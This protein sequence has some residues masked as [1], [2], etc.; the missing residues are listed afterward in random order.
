ME[1]SL[2]SREWPLIAFTLLGQC[3]AGML[4]SW[5][6]YEL[7]GELPP[8]SPNGEAAWIIPAAITVMLGAAGLTA[9]LHLRKPQRAVLAASN[10]QRS[11]LSREMAFSLFFGGSTLL[12]T[13]LQFIQLPLVL[14]RLGL[15][16]AAIVF[17][18]LLLWS[19]I[20]L[21]SLRT[22]PAWNSPATALSFILSAV[23]LGPTALFSLLNLAGSSLEK[24]IPPSPDAAASTSALLLVA[25]PLQMLI[26]YL[27]KRGLAKG[28]RA[29]RTSAARIRGSKT[30]VWIRFY[31]VISAVML[32]GIKLAAG[33][34][35]GP[36]VLC[37]LLMLAAVSET[38]GRFLFYAAYERHGF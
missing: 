16:L 22:V 10:W 20:R 18:G 2:R 26:S 4:A 1:T 31:A 5:F 12:L 23:I 8:L 15:R 17:A 19:M 29:A 33:P 14:L 32:A 24:I 25:L 11:W 36:Q 7:F 28:K 27:H 9:A 35:A 34:L 37:T 38:A 6:A 13:I 3:A 21:Y 30:A